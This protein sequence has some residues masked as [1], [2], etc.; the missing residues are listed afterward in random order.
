MTTLDSREHF[1]AITGQELRL[2]KAGAGTRP[3]RIG[4][5]SPDST[6]PPIHMS[7]STRDRVCVRRWC[8]ASYLPAYGG[9]AVYSSTGFRRGD[10][11]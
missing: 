7:E 1:E 5:V 8:G 9:I 3:T 11:M 4:Y 6:F 10:E 2:R